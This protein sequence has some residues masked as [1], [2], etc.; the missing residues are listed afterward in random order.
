MGAIPGK[1]APALGAFLFGLVIVYGAAPAA[2][3]QVRVQAVVDGDTLRTHDH[4]LVRLIGVNSPEIGKDGAADEPLAVAARSYLSRLL[5]D[6]PVTLVPDQETHDRYGRMLAHV[7]LPDGR[8]VQE[9]L[10]EQ[11]LASLIA[12]PP[13]LDRIERYQAAERRARTQRRGLWS[14]PYFAPV[15]AAQ[16]DPGRTGFR[17]VRGRVQRLGKSGRYI[18][19][20]LSDQFT[21]MIAYADWKY[22][23]G[24][25]EDLVG[26]EVEVSGWV[27]ARGGKLRL[28]LHHAAVLRILE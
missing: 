17:F 22:F 3:L 8:S 18:Y 9:L 27:T 19:L 4:R 15:A 12:L 11:G 20:D 23:P 6:Q 2:A 1:K 28:R 14:H 13:N 7:L 16:L 10:L 24:R 21:C 5:A 25:P 26:K